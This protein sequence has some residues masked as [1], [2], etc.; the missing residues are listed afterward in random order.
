MSILSIDWNTKIKEALERTDIM[1]LSTVDEDGNNWTAPLQYH[2]NSK[3]KLSF[4][5]MMDTKHVQNIL[6]HPR[7]SVAI[8]HPEATPG[9]GH[10]GL[11]IMGTAKEASSKSGGGWHTF[12]IAPDEV[13][14][15]NSKTSR[16]RERVDLRGLEV[17]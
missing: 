12:T 5:S 11:Q 1:A 13:W 10:I 15:F 2:Y 14:Y 9:G 4:Q 6:K 16:E 17:K 3:L 7:V 8:Y